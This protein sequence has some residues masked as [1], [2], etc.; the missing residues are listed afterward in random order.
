MALRPLPGLESVPSEVLLRILQVGI[1]EDILDIPDIKNFK[2]VSRLFSQVVSKDK[3]SIWI[4]VAQRMNSYLVKRFIEINNER[5]VTKEKSVYIYDLLKNNI[6][7][8]VRRA[9]KAR[10][11]LREWEEQEMCINEITFEKMREL[12]KKIL[13][14]AGYILKES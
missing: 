2:L 4:V 6:L 1:E 14:G 8:E 5:S 7:E 9:K 11:L 13:R 10:P 12:N 3:D